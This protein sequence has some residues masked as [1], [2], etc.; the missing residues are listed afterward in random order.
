VLLIA[1]VPAVQVSVKQAV[2]RPR[3]D[4]ALVERRAGFS[5]PSFPSGH[6]L[7]STAVLVVAAGRW[8]GGSRHGVA[9]WWAVGAFVLAGGVANVY[10]GVHW[11]SDVVGGYLWAGVVTTP[12]LWLAMEAA[13]RQ[14]GGAGRT[15]NPH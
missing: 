7:G 2:D 5:S 1:L 11:P 3:P 6:V 15:R 10:E 13:K 8:K 9:A 14:P 12:A 4:P